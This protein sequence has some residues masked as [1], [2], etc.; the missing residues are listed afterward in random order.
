[1]GPLELGDLIGHDV[2]SAVART[3]YDAYFGRVRFTPSLGQAALVAAGRLGRKSGAG[4]YDYGPGAVRPAVEAAQIE[5]ASAEIRT[6]PSGPM[7]AFLTAQG[8]AFFADRDAPR[9]AAEVGPALVA[10]SDGR[11]ARRIARRRERPV[12]VLDWIGRPETAALGFAA[13]CADAGR[14]AR[15]FIGAVGRSA[16]E[17]ADRPGL[18]VLRTMLQL[19]N[20]AGDAARDR[21]A[22]PEAIDAAMLA[23]ANYPI[24][25]FAFLEAFG[26]ARAVRAL[27]RIARETGDPIYLPGESLIARSLD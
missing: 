15:S 22:A 24:G 14:A 6:H 2:N 11:P 3:I 4:V 10:F 20:A 21:I 5:K 27:S 16:V 1:M 12:A 23:G 13:S 19:A 9:R 17:I 7:A 26:P 25:P 18:V 8:A